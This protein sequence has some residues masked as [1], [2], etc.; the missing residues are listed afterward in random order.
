MFCWP[1]LAAE[2]KNSSFIFQSLQTEK[3][4]GWGRRKVGELIDS[5]CTKLPSQSAHYLS[6]KECRELASLAWRV[7][8]DPCHFFFELISVLRQPTLAFCGNSLYTFK[9]P[10]SVPAST[11]RASYSCGQS[12][13]VLE[14]LRARQDQMCILESSLESRP[15]RG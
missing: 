4:R 2:A 5:T 11:L 14:D 15:G 12:V 10:T 3:G 13:L 6:D 7:S 8:H 1:A 9:L